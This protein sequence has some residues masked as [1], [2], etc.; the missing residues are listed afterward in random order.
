MEETVYHNGTRK[1]IC[2]N[3]AE[4]ESCGGCKNHSLLKLWADDNC[5][6]CKNV[7]FG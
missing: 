6:K 3:L 7:D 2:T 1:I 4:C 5:G